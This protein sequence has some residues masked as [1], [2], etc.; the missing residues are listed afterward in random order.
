M[1]NGRS[2]AQWLTDLISEFTLSSPENTLGL[3]TDERAF[4]APLVAFSNGADELYSFYRHHIG[5]FYQ[6]PIDFSKII[7]Q[8]STL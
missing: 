8:I 6:L 2:Q 5:S 1:T 7:F 4:D 3:D